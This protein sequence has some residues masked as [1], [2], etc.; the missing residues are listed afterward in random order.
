MIRNLSGIDTNREEGRL[1]MA[2]LAKITTEL[3]T[4]KTAE[5]VIAMCRDLSGEMFETLLPLSV[6]RVQI[7]L[8]S[9]TFEEV[10]CVTDK[11]GFGHGIELKH[12]PQHGFS[13]AYHNGSIIAQVE[14]GG[15]MHEPM[16]DDDKEW[17]VYD[18]RLED[19]KCEIRT[20]IISKCKEHFNNG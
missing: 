15:R 14:L 3:H 8:P 20:N 4:D 13:T 10:L 11:N 9:A 16:G 1:L 19:W 18:E 7:F 12:F 17:E 6:D 2:A 5:E